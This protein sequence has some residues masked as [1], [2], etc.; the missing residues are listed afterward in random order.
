MPRERKSY[1]DIPPMCSG[2]GLSTPCPK[3][4]AQERF[5]KWFFGGLMVFVVGGGIACLV[6]LTYD[7]LKISGVL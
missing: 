3:C 6:K 7:T 5:S 4:D 2:Y 1:E